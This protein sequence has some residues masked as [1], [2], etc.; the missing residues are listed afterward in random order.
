M[1]RSIIVMLVLCLSQYTV[2][3]C[4]ADCK[5]ALIEEFKIILDSKL[6][7][8]K[9]ELGTFRKQFEIV[10][11]T[12]ADIY[13]STD[14]L[15]GRSSQ[16]LL[17]SEAV[18]KM[19]ETMSEDIR[20]VKE[21]F[22][23][24]ESKL[25]DIETIKTKVESCNINIKETKSE[26]TAIKS[27][28]EELVGFKKVVKEIHKY[29]EGATTKQT[30][31]SDDLQ[32]VKTK[33]ESYETSIKKINP[34][35]TQV[36]GIVSS[37]SVMSDDLQEVKVKVES[38]ETSIKTINPIK[39]EVQS[40]V[41]SVSDISKEN[42]EL[43]KNQINSDN[44]LLNLFTMTATGLNRCPE[45]FFGFVS[46]QCFKVFKNQKTKWSEADNICR[47]EG[48]TLAEPSDRTAMVLTG[49]LLQIYGNGTFWVNARSDGKKFLWQQS[50]KTLESY[51]RLWTPGQPG[52]RVSPGHCLSLLVSEEEWRSYPGQPYH[53]HNCSEIE[54][55]PLC[56]QLLQGDTHLMKS[57]ILYLEENISQKM[58][59]NEIKNNESDKVLLK[60][61]KL[62]QDTQALKSLQLDLE[63]NISQK[64]DG[65]ERKMIASDKL[66]LNAIKGCPV[67]FIEISKQCFKFVF[68]RK[69]SW[70]NAKSDCER[71]GLKLAQP[72]E[73]AFSPLRRYLVQHY[74]DKGYVWMGAQGDGSKLVFQP[75]GES[76]D[77]NSL[78]WYPSY[79][80]AYLG[81]KYCL[82]MRV[83]VGDL[84]SHP[85]QPVDV[86]GCTSTLYALC[87]AI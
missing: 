69:Q 58:D 10:G 70:K 72:V 24:Y 46:T 1:E 28:L 65:M 68:D 67:D 47:S 76:L 21:K 22:E 33:V 62:L 41:S 29:T 12:V 6:N 20:T 75:S 11:G 48:L 52:D 79:P 3:A 13:T 32:E 50:N 2:Q 86:T 4:D 39:S 30:S 8:I 59:D 18:K 51:N 35:M 17:A 42:Q 84:N 74:G 44:M 57:P 14:G 71:R 31:L 55:Y 83:R 81:A 73:S 87:E 23:I 19:Q 56:Q 9:A 38:Y 40:V 7:P 34:I 25:N 78:V 85:G 15:D 26:L 53:S 77:N 80:G 61:I 64:I 60:S 54:H 36:N 37:V 82:S 5:S 66:L 63:V 43:A 27:E 49:F 45:G 16:S